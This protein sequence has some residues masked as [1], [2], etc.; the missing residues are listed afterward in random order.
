MGEEEKG[1]LVPVLAV[2]QIAAAII[3]LGPTFVFPIAG[4]P[5]P[6]HPLVLHFAVEL[7]HQMETGLIIPVA[8]TMFVSGTGLIITANTNV[9]ATTFLLVAIILY[10]TAI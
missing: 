1:E 6:K 2:L 7:Q 10:L 3:A 9:L 4:S 8:L 5:V